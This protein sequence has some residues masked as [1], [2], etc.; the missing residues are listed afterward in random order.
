MIFARLERNLSELIGFV[1]PVNWLVF[2]LLV[3]GGCED[4]INL[5]GTGSGA[6]KMVIQGQLVKGCPSSISIN[7]SLSRDFRSLGL[8]PPVEGVEVI[9]QNENGEQL[10]VPEKDPGFYSMEINEDS[11]NFNIEFGAH[12]QLIVNVS[13][14]DRYV[15]SPEIL[16]EVP[17]P[18]SIS[19]ALV[20]REELDIN[21]SPT[22]NRYVQFRMHTPLATT[23]ARE[24]S[25]LRW[26]F[27]SIYQ[28]TEVLVPGPGPG[29]ATCYVSRNIALDKVVVFNGNESNS[30]RLDDYRVV[31]DKTE[32]RFG[33]GYLLT[34]NQHSLSREAYRYWDQ[35]GEVVGLSGGLFEATPG[36]IKGNLVNIND[37][38]EEVFGYF[39]VSEE[40][41]ITRFVKPSEAGMPR[42]FCD[43]F[44]NAAEDVCTNCRS[45]P[46]S[47]TEKPDGWEL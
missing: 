44:Q 22:L 40:Q 1:N 42:Q 18:D 39:Y 2:L 5:D 32:P 13:D 30:D 24:R 7:L 33:L 46:F 3:I 45:I 34:V 41:K 36:K 15:S 17:S 31:E 47:S 8:P 25:F 28:V 27:E 6:G 35:V 21:N 9:I 29:P 19:I 43:Q 38:S 26:T 4:Q 10:L 37:P 14:E 12:Y 23:G 16:N 20:E 11:T